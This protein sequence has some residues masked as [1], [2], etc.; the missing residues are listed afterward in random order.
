VTKIDDYTVEFKYTQP[1]S[2]DTFYNRCAP[3]VSIAEKKAAEEMGPEYGIKPT[4][5]G[6]FKIV[7][8][9]DLSHCISER[10]PD[11]F[12][13]GLP[14]LDKIHI[15]T[16]PDDATRVAALVAEDVHLSLAVPPK[17]FA[18]LDVPGVVKIENPTRSMFNVHFNCG[19]QWDTPFP[20]KNLRKA[21][22]Y[23]VDFGEVVDTIFEGAG[24]TSNTMLPAW[25]PFY[26][27]DV[28]WNY[29]G[30][31]HD[32]A[33][34][35]LDLAGYPD[36]L[37]FEM[38]VGNIPSLM[39]IA[40]LLQA[41]LAEVN[42][43]A[44]LKIGDMESM[45]AYV[46]SGQYQTFVIWWSGGWT[47]PLMDVGWQA[48]EDPAGQ[49]W[50]GAKAGDNPNQVRFRELWLQAHTAPDFEA[51]KILVDEMQEIFADDPPFPVVCTNYSLYL[52]RDYIKADYESWP[53]MNIHDRWFAQHMYLDK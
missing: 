32:K 7:D 15:K 12:E 21:F 27:D 31:Q 17:T 14:Y 42:M 35:Y 43:K 30:K 3:L 45:Y 16:I 37:E 10:F 6:P 9:V 41:Q 47:D 20:D 29:Q 51:K 36:G 46:F 38:M 28:E 18:S 52:A 19:P 50:Q 49:Y 23:A 48:A 5:T 25:D 44:N 40:T 34:E 2:L 8:F 26:K 11:Y 33:Q 4:G 13:P 24:Q 39:A 22:L 1:I 53:S